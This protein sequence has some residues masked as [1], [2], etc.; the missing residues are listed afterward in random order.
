MAPVVAVF[1]QGEMGAGIGGRLAGQGVEVRTCLEG[2]SEA[3]IARA[4]AAGMTD[5]PPAALADADIFLSIVPPAEARATAER[6][7]PVL[8]GAARKPLYVDCNAVSP[9]SVKEIAA[10]IAATGAPFVDAGILGPRPR[11]GYDPAI[12]AS[13]PEAPRFATLNEYGLRIRLLDGPVGAASALKMCFAGINKGII[14]LWAA[15]IMAAARAGA[16]QALLVEVLEG[17]PGLSASAAK[18]LPTMLHKAYRFGPEMREIGAFAGGPAHR[19]YD[20]IGDLYEEIAR[21]VE[22]DRKVAD[23]LAG[24][25]AQPAKAAE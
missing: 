7:A 1:A 25:F 8:A 11:P 23:L 6:F 4:R 19:I 14:G 17:L 2:R 12:Y 22:G 10:V 24:F 20:G 13:G 9:D 5:A 15:M 18:N 16:D 21:D 3:S